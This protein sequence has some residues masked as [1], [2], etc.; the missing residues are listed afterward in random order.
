MI[1]R[2]EEVS[3]QQAVVAGDCLGFGGER[4]ST[5]GSPTNYSS[6]SSSSNSL[7]VEDD[8]DMLTPT[9]SS[10]PNPAAD[11]VPQCT[12][13]TAST[14]PHRTTPRVEDKPPQTRR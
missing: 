2:L 10:P 11:T 8:D 3:S 9:G 1:Q 5:L 6:S 4:Y 12:Q 14:A 7:S 13:H